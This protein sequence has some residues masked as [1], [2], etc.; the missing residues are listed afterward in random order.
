MGSWFKFNGREDGKFEVMAIKTIFSSESEDNFVIGFGL[1]LLFITVIFY[2]YPAGYY[3]RTS[4]EQAI[5][6]D[7]FF[8]NTLHVPMTLVML[9]NLPEIKDWLRHKTSRFRNFKFDIAI[10]F[11]FFIVIS[12]FGFK[13]GLWI[14]DHF[15]NL[16]VFFVSKVLFTVFTSFHLLGQNLGLSM[17]VNKKS[18]LDS[19]RPERRE[20]ML[21]RVLILAYLAQLTLLI[22]IK[23]FEVFDRN[24]LL[25]FKVNGMFVLFCS[26]LVVINAFTY[27]QDIRKKKVL[28]LSRVLTV[29]FITF[30][31]FAPFASQANHGIEYLFITK[32]MCSNSKMSPELK[33]RTMRFLIFAC[34]AWAIFVMPRYFKF[35]DYMNAFTMTL[36][37]ALLTSIDLVHYWFDRV[38]FRMRYSESRQFIAPLILGNK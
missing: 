16:Y 21:F 20:R 1:V 37:L 13:Q 7:F 6:R 23:D 24:V 28:F 22:F 4:V 8:F 5:L 14:A 11:C 19:T 18:L 29:P 15:Q 36:L 32:K 3:G 26:L 30:T 33:K 17:I 9:F 35:N 2:F 25:I 34:T 10:T 38:L 27:A 31:P 12:F